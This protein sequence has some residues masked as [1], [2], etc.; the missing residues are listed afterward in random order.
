MILVEKIRQACEA[1]NF[2][3]FHFFIDG[4]W[5]L[6]KVIEE[7]NEHNYKRKREQNKQRKQ[8][9]RGKKEKK[10][11][12]NKEG[13]RVEAKKKGLEEGEGEK[14]QKR[15]KGK[16]IEKRR[17]EENRKKGGRKGGLS[18]LAGTA[19]RIFSTV[20]VFPKVMV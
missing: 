14:K 2:Q 6:L 19:M 4:S 18:W 10:N 17:K 7:R 13:E 8:M 20:Y 3:C 5:S 16:K 1:I 11:E 12:K 15:K 9:Q